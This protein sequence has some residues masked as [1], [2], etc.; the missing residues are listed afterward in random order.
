MSPQDGMSPRGLACFGDSCD[1]YDP[2]SMTVWE[3]SAL[4]FSDRNLVCHQILKSP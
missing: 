4:L 1:F 2:A 3:G